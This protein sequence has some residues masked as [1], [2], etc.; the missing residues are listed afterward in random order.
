MSAVDKTPE[1]S[2]QAG[3]SMLFPV[4]HAFAIAASNDDDLAVVTRGLYLGTAGDVK[5]TT[6]GGDTVTFKGLAA[7]II[8]PIRATRVFATGTTAADI[9]GVY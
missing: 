9:L 3:V 1:N 4:K 6:A 5:L 7:G 8:H 2:G